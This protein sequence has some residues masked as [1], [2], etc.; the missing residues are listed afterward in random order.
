MNFRFQK[1]LKYFLPGVLAIIILFW[2]S[3]YFGFDAKVALGYGGDGL[4]TLL[5][6][7]TIISDGWIFVN[8]GTGAPGSLQLQDFPLSMESFHLLIIKAL[9]WICPNPFALINYFY[10]LRFGLVTVTTML[11]LRKLG[12]AYW[13]SVAFGLIYA[14]N[15][16]NII[17]GQGH[18]FIGTYFIVPLITLVMLWAMAGE[19]EPKW[20]NKKFLA[21]LGICVI[22]AGCGIYYSFFACMFLG[23]A[24]VYAAFNAKKEDRPWI[25]GLLPMGFIALIVST[26]VIESIPIFL[27]QAEHGKNLMVGQRE[28]FE[29]ELLGLRFVQLIMPIGNHYLPFFQKKVAEYN[30]SAPFTTENAMSSLGG[31]AAVGLIF[32][33]VWL[34]V[35]NE[36]GAW[37]SGIKRRLEIPVGREKILDHLAIL[38]AFAIFLATIGG[39]GRVIA[40]FMTGI[41]AYNRI[42]IYISF[43]STVAVA[44]VFNG[45]FRKFTQGK[46]RLVFLPV[47]ALFTWGAIMDQTGII[48][49]NFDG[50]V[51]EFHRDRAFV[52]QIAKAMPEKTMIFQLPYFPF[53]EHPPIAK[54][55][56]YEHMKPYLHS[57]PHLHWSYPAMR[58][59]ES[60]TWQQSVAGLP[61][62][63]LIFRVYDK[64]FR[65]IYLDRFGYVDNGEVVIAQ[66]KK[67]LGEP[68]VVSEDG[69]RLFFKLNLNAQIH[70]GESG[71]LPTGLTINDRGKE[72]V[73]PGSIR[74]EKV[75]AL[76]KLSSSRGE[77]GPFQLELSEDSE[78]IDYL[79]LEKAYLSQSSVDRPMPDS[80][81]KSEITCPTEVKFVAGDQEE[82]LLVKVQNRSKFW[83][84]NETVAKTPP[85]LIHV[86][87]HLYNGEMKIIN[88]DF[89]SDFPFSSPIRP[90]GVF[91]K[92][93]TITSTQF[94]QGTSYLEYDLVQE[95]H[96]WAKTVG[97]KTCVVK[98]TKE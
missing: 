72:F 35:R 83:W 18:L 13:I 5:F 52:E 50:L 32:L 60:S 47:L 84:P 3:G 68:A 65:G 14:F 64:G 44:L 80:A 8:H 37:A 12:V 90:G 48:G 49:K 10:F 42:S 96:R 56:D 17:R 71:D 34:F 22:T 25:R 31:V 26:V 98:V 82:A 16:F 93:V 6:I 61:T 4:F 1:F 76:M 77:Q 2:I 67:I 97:G 70:Y 91:E 20:R 43:F 58:G 81:F 36:R 62:D 21:S 59:R 30:A 94:P 55:A 53:P 23:L 54:L 95:G 9:S 86:R 79:Y 28:A 39:F 33:I 63:E 15:P 27:F 88:A 57:P 40:V 75:Q 69:R 29:S 89:K 19:I 73:L 24:G 41:R 46:S 85:L 45:L 38:A 7:K 87:S 92:T 66:L 11:C 78:V 74:S 51:K